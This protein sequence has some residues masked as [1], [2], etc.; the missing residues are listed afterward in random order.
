[1]KVTKLSTEI[2]PVLVSACLTAC[3][4]VRND[5]S[6]DRPN[7]LVIV[8]DD[9]GYTDLGR[10]DIHNS[11]ENLGMAW[12]WATIGAGRADA[13]SAPY[14]GSK[15]SRYEGGIRVPA[16]A[17]HREIAGAGETK[18]PGEMHD[19]IDSHRDIAEE[20]ERAFER[21]SEISHFIRRQQ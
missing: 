14:R 17:W 11:V 19:V 7:I 4:L 5:S 10:S 13:I 20:L 18:H 12:S 3:S 1:M 15:T 9:M 6:Q 16:F 2:S 21:Q 8:I